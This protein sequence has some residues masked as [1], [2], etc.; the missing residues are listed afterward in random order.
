[1]RSQRKPSAWEWLL[2]LAAFLAGAGL[3]G[4]HLAGRTRRTTP[5]NELVSVED[6]ATNG[7]EYAVRG[8]HYLRFTVAGYL[9][10]YDG[11]APK[12]QEVC[13]AVHSGRPIRVWVSK[14]NEAP[15]PIG[16]QVTLY[17]LRVGNRPVLTYAEANAN[18]ARTA[19]A[20]P[21]VGGVLMGLGALVAYSCFCSQRRYAAGAGGLKL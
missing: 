8:R 5:E 13:S 20:V 6:V 4:L 1:M 11:A 15:I 12:Y 16:G 18:R 17:Q 7:H 3:L 10:E 14:K 9:I 2:C 19:N 21:I